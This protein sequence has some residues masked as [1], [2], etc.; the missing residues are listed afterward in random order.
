[1]KSECSI[2]TTRLS[3]LITQLPLADAEEIVD[4]GMLPIPGL[5]FPNQSLANGATSRVRVVRSRSS[6]LLQLDRDINPR[7]YHY[8]KSGR[9]NQAHLDYI[10]RTA[11]ELSKTY[12]KNARILEIGGGAGYLM[13]AL[14]KR[15]FRHLHVIDPSAENLAGQDYQTIQGLFPSG[16]ARG[17]LHFDL[18]IGQH[19]LEHS[20][21]PV[22][23]LRAAEE[24]L[25]PGGH[26]WIE[27]PDITASALTEQGEWLSIIYA[28]HSAYFDCTTLST[29]A[30]H[31]GLEMI[32]SYSVDHY[33]KSLV[34][35]FEKRRFAES[36]FLPPEGMIEGA[37]AVRAAIRAYFS[38]L[39]EFGR[40]L[41]SGILC[42]GAAERCLTVLGACMAGGF[43]PSSICDSNPDLRGLYLSGM[44]QPVLGVGDIT[45]KIDSVLILSPR[46][47][48]AIVQSN[49]AL[50]RSDAQ[51]YIP[52][53]GR[54]AIEQ[55]L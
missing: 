28:C 11:E 52:F 37:D 21:E 55:I 34:A 17:D 27:V 38:N 23:V 10:E 26:V 25:T 16:L 3:D 22:A 35:I 8:Y 48:K 45:N 14:A 19:F 5:F 1:M 15:G 4:L 2:S 6:G 7:L 24:L 39:A 18:I 44:T 47:A 54:L 20:A 33:G 53:T 41:P 40:S 30:A 32:R 51:V 9:V 12:P 36:G 46:N 31:A 43:N 13:R 29:A 42:W 50:F 49:S